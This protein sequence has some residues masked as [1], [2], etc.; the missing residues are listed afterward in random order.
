M[1]NP[2]KLA[3]IVFIILL[4]LSVFLGVTGAYSSIADPSLFS[5]TVSKEV[6]AQKAVDYIS[7]NYLA[8][9]VTARLASVADES[10]VYKV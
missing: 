3:C 10:G 8:A 4:A 7:A 5:S 9:G 2:W 1:D 6:T